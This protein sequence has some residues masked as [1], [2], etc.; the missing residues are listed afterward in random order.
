ML[1]KKYLLVSV[2]ILIGLTSVKAQVAASEDANY[3]KTIT[4]RADKIVAGL[5]ITDSAK[6]KRVQNVIINQYRSLSTIHDTRNAQVKDI[7]AQPSEDKTADNAKV[8]AIDDDVD[9]KLTKLHGEYLSKLGAEIDAAQIE[10]VKDAM[11]YNKVEVTYKGYLAEIP[12]L[13]EPQKAQIKAWLIEAREKAIDAG[14]S[15]DKTAI[16]GKYKGRINNYLSAQGYDLKKEQEEWQKR[17][18][19]GSTGN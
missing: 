14:S 15:D 10:K 7:K 3:T 19:A 1:I 11:T 5:G 2:F 9:A 13:T 12:T 16:F 8:K 6:Y 4:A 17:I 18:K